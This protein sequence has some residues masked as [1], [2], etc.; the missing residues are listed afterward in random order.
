MKLSKREAKCRMKAIQEGHLMKDEQRLLDAVVANGLTYAK[1]YRGEGGVRRD[2]LLGV[3]LRRIG[4]AGVP[5]KKAADALQKF[6]AA[7]AA[8]ALSMQTVT[9]GFEPQG[10]TLE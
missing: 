1:F 9:L 4:K 2:F 3:H 5:A 6:S 7:A 10:V 8:C